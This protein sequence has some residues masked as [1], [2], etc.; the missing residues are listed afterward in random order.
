MFRQFSFAIYI[1]AVT[2][3][4]VRSRS[5]RL[6]AGTHY[7]WGMAWACLSSTKWRHSA[8]APQKN[9]HNTLIR[10]RAATCAEVPL[11]FLFSCS[12]SSFG[13]VYTSVLADDL[14][15]KHAECF[16]DQG[17]SKEDAEGLVKLLRRMLV[18]DPAGRPSALELLED[19]YLTSID[20]EISCGYSS[21]LNGVPLSLPPS[22][23]VV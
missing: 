12:H 3:D 21:V 9:G 20:V 14:W 11:L 7:S 17:T 10:C 18:I 4:G 15:T 22:I 1:F 19:P 8:A 2:A 13:V 16:I 6:Q 5:I 23:S